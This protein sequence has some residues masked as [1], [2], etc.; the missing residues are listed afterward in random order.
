MKMTGMY[1]AQGAQL[2]ARA[3][4]EGK[5]LTIIRAAAGSQLTDAQATVMAAQAQALSIHSK[6]AQDTGCTVAAVLNAA[7]ASQTYTLRE[8][9]LFACLEGEAE[10][11]YKLFRLD[12]SLL[13]E[14]GTDLVVTVYLTETILPAQQVQ[15]TVSQQGLVTQAICTQTARE[16]AQAVQANLEAHKTDSSAHSA[17]FATKANATHKHSGADIQAGTMTGIVG[18]MSNIAYTTAQVRSIILSTADPAGGSNGQVWIKY[19]E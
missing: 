13:V 2:A 5:A 10:V 3:L 9:A 18:A 8:V 6:V 1:T 12:E 19:T 17:V 11:L 14:A 15:V 7:D 16:E 4:A